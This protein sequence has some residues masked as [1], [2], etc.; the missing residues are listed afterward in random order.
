[1]ENKAKVWLARDKG[2]A[3]WLYQ[4]IP[5]RDEDGG[6]LFCNG[7]ITQ[8]DSSSFPSVKW[9]DDEPTEAYITLTEPQ[10]QRK[11]EQPTPK[12][13]ID[14]EQRRYEIAKNLYEQYKDMDEIGAVHAANKLI[15]ELKSKANEL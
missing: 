12:Q 9:E 11:Q 15:N 13:E 6:I 3:L 8:L 14:W 4:S 10:E 2:G 5:L 1:M 7:S